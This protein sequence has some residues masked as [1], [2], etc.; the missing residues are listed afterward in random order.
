MDKKKVFVTTSFRNCQM[1]NYL[2]AQISQFAGLNDCEVVDSAEASDYIVVT[3]CGFDQPR[4]DH[5]R[6]MITQ[7][8]NEHPGKKVVVSGCLPGIAPDFNKGLDNVIP[9]NT[10]QLHGFDKLFE[11]KVAIKTVKPNVIEDIPRHGPKG[12]F[13]I[14]ISKGCTN[15]CTFCVI[16]KTKGRLHSK[17]INDIVAEIEDGLKRG[18]D[19]FCFLSDNVSLYG[20]DLR[21]DLADLLNRVGEIEGDFKV[22]L[23][24]A[25]P[26]QFAPLYPKITKAAMDRI[27]YLDLPFQSGSQALL[28]EM[29][30]DYIPSDVVALAKQIKREHPDVVLASHFIIGFPGET[31]EDFFETL[32]C[33][34]YFDQVTFFPYSDRAGTVAAKMTNHVSQQELDQRTEIVSQFVKGNPRMQLMEP[35]VGAGEHLDESK[36]IAGQFVAGKLMMQVVQPAQSAGH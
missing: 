23:Y 4:E 25:H 6:D 5:S 27:C 13:N 35:N 14:E 32:S 21:I 1:N 10:D 7:L 26:R 3:T 19:R 31:M 24:Y 16:W 9:I 28:K 17:S 22:M 30:R 2:T 15:R 18:Y 11:A 29:K 36:P 20:I 12:L 33:A 34:Q 8:A